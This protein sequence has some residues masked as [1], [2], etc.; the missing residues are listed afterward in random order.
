[1]SLDQRKSA[2]HELLDLSASFDTVDHGLLVNHLSS[3]LGIDPLEWIH[4]YLTNRIQFV[5]GEDYK[6]GCLNL[7]SGIPQRSV[8]GSI[9]F[10]IYTQP[11]GDIIHQHN[12]Q[13]H[14]Y[15]NDTQLYLTF[16]GTNIESEKSAP[17]QIE[18]CIIEIKDW[19]HHNKIKLNGDKTEFLHFYPLERNS[20]TAS[21]PTITVEKT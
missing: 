20:T 19:M 15:A 3:R 6:S 13:F 16:D 7:A 9:F 21:I 2:S 17:S 14:F 5:S 1:M 11:L 10:T 12:M 8:L 4:S 18:R